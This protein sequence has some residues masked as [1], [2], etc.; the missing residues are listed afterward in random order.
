MT[1]EDKARYVRW[2]DYR[3]QHLGYVINLFLGFGVASIGF[4]WTQSPKIDDSIVLWWVTSLCAGVAAIVC[5]LVDFRYTCKKIE[6]GNGAYK[7][8]TNLVG[9]ITWICCGVQLLSYSVGI[10]KVLFDYW[11]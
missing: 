9:H 4:A 3:I 10:G 5:R 1:E 2:Q 7:L 11:K 8:L 6:S